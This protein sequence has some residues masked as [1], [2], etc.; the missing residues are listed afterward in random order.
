M[1]IHEM[2]I[3]AYYSARSNKKEILQKINIKLEQLRYL[4]RLCFEWHYINNK[5][6]EYISGLL[7]QLGKKTGA[8]INSLK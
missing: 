3:E 6:Y 5:R 4:I 1:D 8:W 7:L 2:Y